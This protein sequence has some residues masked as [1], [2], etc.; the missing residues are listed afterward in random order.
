MI[1][2]KKYTYIVNC[3]QST[4]EETQILNKKNKNHKIC[5]N[6]PNL[7]LRNII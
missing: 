5:P 6:I 1:M 2:N 4:T 3:N 7:V